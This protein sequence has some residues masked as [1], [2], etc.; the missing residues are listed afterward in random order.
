MFCI[1]NNSQYTTIMDSMVLF[2]SNL[3]K[4]NKLSSWKGFNIKNL[5]QNIRPQDDFFHFACG[6]WIKNNPIPATKTKWG[7][8]YLLREDS[9]K[10]IKKVVEKSIKSTNSKKGSDTQM[11]GDFYKSG[12]NMKIRNKLGIEPIQDL[13]NQ[14]DAIS[15]QEDVVN[16]ITHTHSKGLSMVWGTTVAQDDKDGDKN[17]IFFYQSGLTL[18]DRDFYLKKDTESVEIQK[19]FKK[20]ITNTL[21]IAKVSTKDNPKAADLIFEFE[22]KLAKASMDKIHTRD[23]EKLYNKKTLSQLQKLAPFINWKVFLNKI[24]LKK[25]TEVVVTQPEYL[26]KAT[27]MIQTESLTIWKLYLQWQVL[28]GFSSLLSDKFVKNRFNFYGKILNG[29]K[30][31]EP[32]WKRVLGTLENNIGELI[33]KEYVKLYFPPE[34]KKEINELVDN[35]FVAFEKRLTS[36]DWMT[37]QTKKKALFKLKNMSRKLGYPD[38]WK[39]YKGLVLRS[40]TYVENVLRSIEFHKQKDF[41]KLDKKVDKKEWFTTPQTVNAF[42]D[43]NMNE[44]VFPAGILQ[45]PFFDATIDDAINYGAIGSIIGHEMTHGFDDQGAKFDHKGNFKNWWSSQDKKRF[46]LKTKKLV[47]QF[48]KYK[49]GSLYVN[50]KMTLGENIADLGGLAIAYD[51]YQEH[52]KHSEKKT[53]GGFTPEQRFFLGNVLVE[54]GHERP[55]TA[56]MLMLTDPHCLPVFRIN[57]VVSNLLEFYKAF[58]VTKKDKLYKRP[59]EQPK[60]W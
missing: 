53:L 1:C 57:G 47:T 44:I 27:L 58:G 22:K 46:E 35:L 50:G 17:S 48:N 28:D 8:F 59:S 32:E 20:Y 29:Q 33:G 30:Q 14:I 10:K 6:G 21:K 60:I 25:A 37:P 42:Y 19:A 55:E 15:S 16:F 9:L 11:V 12:L 2:L 45:R 41:K 54:Q 40:D 31:I 49:V 4:K 36:N 18:P 43:P 56:R 34:A 26:Q 39:S 7:S 38:K 24:G 5:D 13:L 51:A 23:I 3:M 52:L